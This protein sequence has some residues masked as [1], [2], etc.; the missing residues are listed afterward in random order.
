MTKKG[1][2]VAD[3]KEEVERGFT[4]MKK[5]YLEVA[6]TV[7][8]KPRKKNKPWISGESRHRV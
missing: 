2:E 8:G 4:A 5:A 6:E 3:A 1:E 7:L